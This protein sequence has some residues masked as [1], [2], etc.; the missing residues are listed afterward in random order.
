MRQ[1][2]QETARDYEGEEAMT[3][4]EEAEKAWA[5]W[6]NQPG[7]AYDPDILEKCWMA[8][9]SAATER[10]AKIAA[11]KC[12]CKQGGIAEIIGGCLACDVV[13]AIRGGE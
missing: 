12:Q 6:S 5:E 3:S 9:W 1:V 4:S 11:D 8:A 10:A 7:D 2:F 13:A